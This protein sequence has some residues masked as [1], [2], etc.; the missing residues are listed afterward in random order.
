[1]EA[2]ETIIRTVPPRPKGYGVLG[3]LGGLLLTAGIVCCWRMT[4]PPIERTNLFLYAKSSAMDLVSVDSFLNRKPGRVSRNRYVENVLRTQVYGGKGAVEFCLWPLTFGGITTLG[5]MLLGARIDAK[6]MRDLRSGKVQAGPKLITRAEFNAEQRKGK[7]VPGVG[8]LLK[9]RRSLRESVKGQEGYVLRIPKRHESHHFSI[10]GAP[11]AGKTQTIQQLVDQVNDRR[12]TDTAIIWDPTGVLT[13]RYYQADQGDIILNPMDARCPSWNPKWELSGLNAFDE[14]TARAMGSSLYVGRAASTQDGT[15]FFSDTSIDLWTQIVAHCEIEE[16]QDLASWMA[17]PEP[18]LDQR[19]AGSKCEQDLNKNSAPQRNGILSSFCMIQG[20]LASIPT[21]KTASKWTVKDWCEKRK[22][23][24]FL[25]S[26]PD[27]A[28]TIRPLQSLWIDMLIRR[29]MAQRER[30]DLRA[31]WFFFDELAEL[32]RLPMLEPAMNQGRKF[33]LRMVLGFQAMSQVEYLYGRDQAQAI[34][35]APG[36]QI[37]MRTM[38]HTSAEWM[39]KQCG[40]QR[41]ERLVESFAASWAG[42]NK[43]QSVR[44]EVVDIALFIP[45]VFM[46]LADMRGILRHGNSLVLLQ[47]PHL[48]KIKRCPAFIPR[49]DIPTTVTVVPTTVTVADLMTEGEKEEVKSVGAGASSE[50]KAGVY[51]KKEKAGLA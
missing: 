35:A 14:A 19:V 49:R 10:A 32:Q 24:I 28:E 23:W 7:E 46:G 40:L 44:T 8:L 20:S 12:E 5:L 15:T 37:Y 33:N 2:N 29:L 18:E 45:S 27:T 4:L 50:G 48:L 6:F 11:G 9:N 34:L 47:L 41:I 39:S 22:G 25:T 26:T 1:M 17:N 36:L 38:E 42:N 30:P 21:S 31:P 3:V 43:G 16:A 13:E 51:R